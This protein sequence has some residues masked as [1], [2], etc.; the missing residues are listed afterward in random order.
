M[1]LTAATYA[2]VLTHDPKIDDVAL[3]I[4]LKSPVRYIGALGSRVTQAKRRDYLTQLGFTSEDLARIHGPIG[5]N[6]GARTPEEIA[7]CIAAE[8]VQ[9]RRS[10]ISMPAQELSQSRT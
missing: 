2:V 1:K 7:L 9:V 6:I 10:R 3:S 5:L 8:I 4:F